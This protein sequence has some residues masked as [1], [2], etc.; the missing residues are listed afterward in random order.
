MYYVTS[1]IV[2]SFTKSGDQREC[3]SC[4]R[5]GSTNWLA[6]PLPCEKMGKLAKSLPESRPDPS[7]AGSPSTGGKIAGR[8]R[9][10]DAREPQSYR[11]G[12]FLLALH[13]VPGTDSK[14]GRRE[15]LPAV[16]QANRAA[17]DFKVDGVPGSDRALLSSCRRRRAEVY[18]KTCSSTAGE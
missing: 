16:G 8:L 15:G 4:R 17:H 10:L 18:L 14:E 5:W 3:P 12:R 11:K 6:S 13:A 1:D 7:R 2:K 9:T